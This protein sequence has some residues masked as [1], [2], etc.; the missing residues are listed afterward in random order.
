[1]ICPGRGQVNNCMADDKLFAHNIRCLSLKRDKGFLGLIPVKS[2][3]GR[4]MQG[5]K[6]KSK[7]KSI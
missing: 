6:W 2:V 5:M 4:P 3:A 1:M 7:P